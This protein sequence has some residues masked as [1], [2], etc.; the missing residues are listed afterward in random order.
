M[1]MD[2]YAR[3]PFLRIVCILRIENTRIILKDNG[4]DVKYLHIYSG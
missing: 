4:I 1:H 2:A 3:T